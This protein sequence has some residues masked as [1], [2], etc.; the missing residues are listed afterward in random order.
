MVKSKLV[1][2]KKCHREIF[3]LPDNYKMS[4][5]VLCVDC[6]KKP[7]K[8]KT[9]TVKVTAAA[10]Y[11]RT[12]KGVR[13]DVHPTYYFKSAT[14]ANFAR[15]L[16]Y[17]NIKWSYEERAFTFDGYKNKPYIYIIDFQI[18]GK[19]QTKKKD[20][21]DKL[22]DRFIEVKGYMNAQSRNKLRRYKK[23]YPEEAQNTC[24]VIYTKY[25]KADIEFCTKLGFRYIFY[26]N[27]TKHYEP[28]IPTWE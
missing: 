13:K 19:P 9:K 3:Y 23:H 26:D 11:A 5:K 4:C 17:H 24:V 15:I 21:L 16:E 25:R 20:L 12:K 22:G 10:N 2:C 8:R 7:T 18:L 14:E 27:L 28:L 1:S 6:G